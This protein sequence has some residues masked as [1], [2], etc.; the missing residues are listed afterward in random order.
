MLQHSRRIKSGQILL[1]C[2]AFGRL[3]VDKW[4]MEKLEWQDLGLDC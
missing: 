1:I 4:R 3:A 2:T